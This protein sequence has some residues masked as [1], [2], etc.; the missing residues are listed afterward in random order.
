MIWEYDRQWCLLGCHIEL[1]FGSVS[2]YQL[3]RLHWGSFECKQAPCSIRCRFQ[4][5]SAPTLRS[6]DDAG[7]E[8]SVWKVFKSE[9]KVD[10]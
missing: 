7:C 10:M 4:S 6:F 1:G 9:L 8:A 2:G 3:M 5:A